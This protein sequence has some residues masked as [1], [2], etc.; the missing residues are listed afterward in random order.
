MKIEHVAMY[1]HDPEKARDFFVKYFNG[2]SNEGYV[3]PRTGF[4][5][6]F[7][8]FDDGARL[9][10]MQR[11]DMT[12]SPAD[13][14]R[15]GFIHIAFSVGS[16]ETVDSL[17][18]RLR[19]DGFTVVSGPRTTGDGYYESCVVAVEDNQVEITV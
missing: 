13:L 15:T 11:P 4:R 9:E 8:T 16:R 12:D 6:F 18:D 10:I 2:R 5:S 17:T 3:N 7:I 14:N 1:V 19:N